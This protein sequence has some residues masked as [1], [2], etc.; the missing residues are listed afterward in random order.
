MKKEPQRQEDRAISLLQKRGMMRLS[1]FLEEGITAATISRMEQRAAVNQ[2]SRGLYQLPDAL[3][4]ANHS[5]AV[6]AK[7]IPN[8]V[9]C[10]GSALAFHELTDHVPPYV[11][12][13]IGPRD[14]R[15][16]ISRPRIEIV[17]FGPKEFD[18]GIERHIIE[19]VSVPIY[20]PAKSIVDLFKSGQR[21]RAFHKAPAGLAQ[22]TQ[23]M[24][25]ALRQRKATPSEIAKYAVEAGIWKKVVQPRLE[26]L[27]ID[28]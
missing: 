22:A 18:K 26:T 9:I 17:R 3:L 10:Y 12:M 4:D 11:W 20:V 5:L 14:W 16:K 24:K 8:G 1:E 21:P 28:A 2:L 13:A 27:T 19:G 23:A 7:L 25:D 15:P 6:A